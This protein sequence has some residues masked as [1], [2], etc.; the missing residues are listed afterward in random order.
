MGGQRD[1]FRD[2]DSIMTPFEYTINPF[3]NN[4]GNIGW[5]ADGDLTTS[6]PDTGVVWGCER[7]ELLLAETL[8]FHDHR[9]EDL[10]QDDVGPDHASTSTPLDPNFDQRLL[11]R[12]SLFIELYNPWITPRAVATNLAPAASEAS[13]EFYAIDTASN[14]ATGV[15]LNALTTTGNSPVWRMLIV[16]GTALQANGQPKDPDDPVP[17]NR[18]TFNVPAVPADEVERSIYFAQPPAAINDHGQPYFPAAPTAPLLPGRYAVIGSPGIANAA[19][20]ITTIGRLLNASNNPDTAQDGYVP[21]KTD[22]TRRIVLTPSIDPTA[23]QVQVLSNGQSSAL[24]GAE[25]N[26]AD[27]QAA[28]AVVVDQALSA[29]VAVSRPVSVSEPLNGY[30][31]PMGMG[32]VSNGEPIYILP[33][34]I[35]LD[36]DS[37]PINPQ[38]NPKFRYIHLQR[39][40]DPT[41]PWNPTPFLQDGTTPNPSYNPSLQINPYLTIDTASIPLVVF[42]GVA[43]KPDPA[44]AAGP[45]GLSS[46]QR[47]LNQLAENYFWGVELGAPN[48]NS[49]ASGGLPQ[50]HNFNFFL[51]HS[52]GY[53]NQKY[54]TAGDTTST[55]VATDPIVASSGMAAYKGAPKNTPFP[56]LTWNNRPFVGPAEIMLVPK[57]RSSRLL[58]DYAMFPAQPYSS[59][60]AIM[61]MF[62]IGHLL[63]LFQIDEPYTDLNTNGQYDIGEPYT[64][65]NGNTVYDPAPDLHR[66]L[67]Y[68][69]VPSRFVGTETY[70]NPQTLT[71]FFDT[72]GT[73][74]AMMSFFHPPFNK[75]S[76]YREPGRVNINTIPSDTVANATSAIW[77]GI[78][79]SAPGVAGTPAWAAVFQSRQGSNLPWTAAASSSS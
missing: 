31:I 16:K 36:V 56:W 73:E 39:L 60:T 25:P 27:I 30:A 26:A 69:Q 68:V 29:G 18:P 58:F 5:T 8:A 42:N 75:V 41:Q 33:R 47:G 40:A 67:E 32:G 1:R 57:S 28:I 79:N 63:S 4:P 7:P 11:P 70:L 74:Q 54:G 46:T 17:A 6:E 3:Q 14:V 9:T 50:D 10:A 2:R 66:I 43:D 62:G 65:L 71:P 45:Q 59:R 15:Q 20:Y 48:S 52:L 12:G 23:P 22:I 76:N 24:G 53:L 35:P 55:Y 51:F 38:T 13:G 19:T 21:A 77:N 61:P 49:V 64:D 44:I 37:N 34:D 78:I 72:T